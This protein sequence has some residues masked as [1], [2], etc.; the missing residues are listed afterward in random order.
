MEQND[1]E[2]L[3]SHFNLTYKNKIRHKT[4]HGVM[5]RSIYPLIIAKSPPGTIFNDEAT[6]TD[7]KVSRMS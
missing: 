6:F 3:S 5:Q 7:L 4:I 2:K 1:F